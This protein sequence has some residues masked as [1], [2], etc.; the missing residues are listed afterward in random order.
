[1]V[2]EL[3]KY[4][5]PN[6]VELHNYAAASN[7]QQKMINWGLLNRKVFQRFDL[8]VP[9]NIVRGICNGKSGLVETFLYNLRVKIDE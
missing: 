8:N 6:W 9:E 5:F 7:T 1:M 4:Y 3:V 2:A